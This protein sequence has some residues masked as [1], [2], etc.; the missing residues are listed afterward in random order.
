MD[1]F[2]TKMS[3][4]TDLIGFKKVKYACKTDYDLV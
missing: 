1:I 2:L 4:T 3:E